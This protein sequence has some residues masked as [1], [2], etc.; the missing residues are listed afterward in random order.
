VKEE[1]CFAITHR[2]VI[3]FDHD[4]GN[5]IVEPFCYGLH[6][7]TGNEVLRG[8]QVGGFSASGKSYGWK[9][10]RVDQI[11][12]LSVTDQNFN[13]IREYYNPND[14]IMKKI[15]CRIEKDNI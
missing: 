1:I 4:G 12:R 2:R 5:R 11:S 15:I 7:N 9:L 3:S 10:Y 13:G 8:Y 6:K 14:S